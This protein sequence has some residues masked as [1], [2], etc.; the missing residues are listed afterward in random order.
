MNW[1]TEFFRLAV[2][3]DWQIFRGSGQYSRKRNLSRGLA[4]LT[5]SPSRGRLRQIGLQRPTF[6]WRSFS[7]LLLVNSKARK[8]FRV[9]VLLGEPYGRVQLMP[10]PRRSARI[11]ALPETANIR[12]T[13]EFDTP[14]GAQIGVLGIRTPPTHT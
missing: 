3:C 4:L 1:T 2:N 6:L 13:I 14:V 7:R 5:D 10:V 8:R 12:G 11:A 9:R